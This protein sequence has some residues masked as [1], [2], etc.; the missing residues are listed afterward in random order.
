MKKEYNEPFALRLTCR[1]WNWICCSKEKKSWKNSSVCTACK[2][3]NL[4]G[5][6]RLFQCNRILCLVNHITTRSVAM[7]LWDVNMIAQKWAG[8]SYDDVSR[9]MIFTCIFCTSCSVVICII[10][11][12]LSP[13][14]TFT[15]MDKIECTTARKI[16]R[17][18]FH[19]PNLLFFFVFFALSLS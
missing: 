17:G 19:E 6:F 4:R 18:L 15:V 2:C 7:L 13:S 8:I 11:S 12:D 14:L 5:F 1:H 9:T 3:C 16:S 10:I